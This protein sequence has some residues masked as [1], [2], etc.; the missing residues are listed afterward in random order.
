MKLRAYREFL[1]LDKPQAV[2]QIKQVAKMRGATSKV[3][4]RRYFWWENDVVS[5]NDDLIEA[6]YVWSSGKV[7][8]SDFE[9]V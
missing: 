1:G 2:E 7:C 6:I 9:G 3:T 4:Y 5:P 8:K